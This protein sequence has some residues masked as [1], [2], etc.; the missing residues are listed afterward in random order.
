MIAAA[1]GVLVPFTLHGMGRD[2]AQGSSVLLTFVT[3]SMGFSCSSASHG[4]T[5]DDVKK[6]VA[7]LPRCGGSQN[8]SSVSF[9]SA[10]FH[11]SLNSRCTH[12]AFTSFPCFVSAA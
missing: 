4:C 12:M 1:V 5:C 2:P 3:D 11:A 9:T 7:A 8:S 6:P 10:F